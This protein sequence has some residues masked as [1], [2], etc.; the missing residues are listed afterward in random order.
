M[1]LVVN[2]DGN[3]TGLSVGGL[4]SSVITSTNIVDATIAQGDL[5]TNVVGNG[6]AFSAVP[7]RCRAARRD[8]RAVDAPR[9]SGEEQRRGAPDPS[10][11]GQRGHSTCQSNRKQPQQHGTLHSRLL[12]L[13][14]RPRRKQ[15]CKRRTR[16][17]QDGE[18][19]SAHGA[20]HCGS[21]EVACDFSAEF[22]VKDG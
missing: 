20:L 7:Q 9:L 17:R 12:R 21:R 8:C 18:P 13:A 1:A 3:I 4:P 11:G 14:G 19:V 16:P 15:A 10:V 22:A 5:A 2:G 6:P